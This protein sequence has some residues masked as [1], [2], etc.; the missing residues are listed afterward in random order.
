MINFLRQ[1]S[2]AQHWGLVLLSGAVLLAAAYLGRHASFTWI[3]LV[4]GAAASLALL[5]RPLL[6]LPL[7][8][9]VS[10]IAPVAIGTGTEVSLNPAAV[11]VPTAITI[12]L[13]TL[14]RRRHVRLAKSSTNRPLL[15]FLLAGLLSLLIGNALWDPAVPRS[16]HFI[17]VQLA[18]W[19][20]FAFSAGAFWLTANLVRD[21]RQLQRLTYFFLFAA[22]GLALVFV[23]V[24]GSA[25]V[26]SI[27]TV[28]L[29]RAPFWVL[30]VALTGGQLL[31]NRS[32]S[33]PWRAFLWACL[34]ATL[35]YAFVEQR[36]AASNWVGIAAVAGTLLWLRFPRLRVAV[37]VV[38]VLLVVVGIFLPAVYDFAGGDAEWNTSGGSR[39]ALSE[40]VIEVTLRNPITGLGPASYRPYADSKPLLYGRAYW[41]DPRINSHNNYV[42]LFAHV[43]ILGLMLFFWFVAALT[44]VGLRLHKRFTGGFTAGYVNG[45]LAAGAG[46][47]VIMALADWML[48]FVYNIGFEGF[49]ASVLVWMFLGGLVAIENFDVQADTSH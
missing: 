40:R 46:A 6:F 47:L 27:F 25:L 39:L 12:W 23:L 45:M 37:I 7:I 18:Q 33:I 43:G 26:G 16:D 4:A 22:G 11:L 14:I 24:N 17:L 13:F 38:A 15:L 35:F 49:Q 21:A 1:R 30:L 36:E 29:I 28:A 44:R 8:I 34:A 48:P 5:R 2:L 41:L 31:F 19:S 32:L 9:V 10:L 42:D 20:I 3:L